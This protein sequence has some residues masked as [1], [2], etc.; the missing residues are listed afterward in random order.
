MLSRNQGENMCE[1]VVFCAIFFDWF[2]SP[3]QLFIFSLERGYT[4]D[5]TP[6][7]PQCNEDEILIGKDIIG[8]TTNQVCFGGMTAICCTA[9]LPAPADCIFTGKSGF[10]SNKTVNLT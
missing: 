10:Y 3:T 9:D 5:K 1:C 8:D 4:D 2:N 6:C 7:V